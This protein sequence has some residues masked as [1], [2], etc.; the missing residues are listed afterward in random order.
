MTRIVERDPRA[1]ARRTLV[2]LVITVSLLFVGSLIFM[3]VEGGRRIPEGR[4]VLAVLPFQA[5]APGSS[6]YAGFGEG[7]ASFFGRIDPRE[8]SVLGPASTARLFDPDGD[9]LEVGR[10]LEADLILM[11]REVSSASATTVVAELYRVDSGT[12]LWSGEFDVGEP[13]DLRRVQALIGMEVTEALNLP[14]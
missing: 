5:S 4:T 2:A 1:G 8:I 13:E 11:G 9:P 12:L 3:V 6:R 7:L 14:R 10:Q